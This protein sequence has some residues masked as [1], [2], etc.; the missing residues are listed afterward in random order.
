MIPSTNTK[1][2]TRMQ[3]KSRL[4]TLIRQT[5]NRLCQTFSNISHVQPGMETCWITVTP[6]SRM[7]IKLTLSWLLVSPLLYS[8]YTYGC[9]ATHSSNIIVKFVDDM[10]VVGLIS[11]NKPIWTRWTCCHHF[12]RTTT[13]T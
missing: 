3:T 2:N 12:V 1:P 8:L 6:H 13:W 10:V 9:I 11:N 4:L 5:S 7:V